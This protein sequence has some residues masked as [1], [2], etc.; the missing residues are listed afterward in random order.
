LSLNNREII[1]IFLPANKQEN[2]LNPLNPELNPTCHLLALLE[3]YHILHLSRIRV[4]R[5][6]KIYNKTAPKYFSEITFIRERTI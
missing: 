1:K 4:K 3:A 6:I 5:N 2:C